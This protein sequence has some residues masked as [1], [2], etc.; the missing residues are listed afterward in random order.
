[1]ST[2]YRP[3]GCGSLY[4]ER[5]RNI[6]SFFRKRKVRLTAVSLAILVIMAAISQ[7]GDADID[8]PWV[9]SGP[10]DVTISK[11]QDE[12]IGI[13]DSIEKVA[14]H[15]KKSVENQTD[16]L[17]GK[18]SEYSNTGGQKNHASIKE[19]IKDVVDKVA[20]G[21]GKASTNATSKKKD[22]Y[23]HSL[24]DTKG[25]VIIDEIPAYS[26][27]SY[28]ILNKNIPDLDLSD[29]SKGTFKRFSKLDK[30]GRTG[31]AYACIGKESLPEEERGEIGM[32]KPSGWIQ[33]KY[34]GV[35][36]GNYLYNR[37]HLIAYCLSGE[38]ANPQNLITGTR[39]LN[40]GNDALKIGDGMLTFETKTVQ[41]IERTGNHVLYKVT[42]LYEGEDL[43][44]YGVMMEAE[45]VEDNGK[46]ICFS[47]FIYNAQEGVSISYETG[48]NRLDVNK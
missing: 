3:E 19:T 21:T 25:N 22:A 15:I 26:G 5:S 10:Q 18:A 11:G 42:P 28:C 32:V 23:V 29:A 48:D 12:N 17:K 9:S 6:F 47:V 45:S 13:T 14:G 7:Y 38:N 30:L 39:Q 36:E 24:K 44:T 27:E 37:C 16:S 31:T 4:T 34:A 8:Y 43:L 2:C 41:Y 33:N 1:M 35:V 46:G 40:S 20:N